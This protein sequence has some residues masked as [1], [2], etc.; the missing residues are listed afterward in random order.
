MIR[1]FKKEYESTCDYTLPDYMG[2]V[3]KVLLT[4][5]AVIPS[6]AFGSSESIDGTGIVE[7]NVIYLDSDGKM[8]A[9]CFTSDYEISFPMDFEPESFAVDTAISSYSVH[10]SAPRRFSAKATVSSELHVANAYVDAPEGSAFEDGR[11]PE[12]KRE[13]LRAESM[14]TAERA[15]R[16]YAETLAELGG[17]TA[18]DIEVISSGAVLR[19]EE[20][21]AVTDGVNVKGTLIV[22]AIVR[23]SEQAPFAIKREFPFEE[24]IRIE[25]AAPDMSAVVS[26]TVSSATCTTGEGE[27]V[28]TVV[29]NV[30][31]DFDARLIYNEDV[32]VTSDAYLSELDTEESYA[33][34]KYSALRGAVST[35]AEISL[36]NLRSE[37]GLLD[38]RELLNMDFDVRKCRLDTEDGT[39]K[40]RGELA[41]F[42]I[43]SEISEDGAA[44]YSPVRFSLPFEI[45]LGQYARLAPDSRVSYSVSPAGVEW[46]LDA[47]NVYLRASVNLSLHSRDEKSARRLVSCNAV[48]EVEYLPSPSRITVYYPEGGETLFSVAKKF[49]TTPAQ[50]SL[51]NEITDTVSTGDSSDVS[52]G[53]TKILVRKIK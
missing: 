23:T 29:A 37:S 49:H 2:D 28:A 1:K 18:D 5:A 31:A 4:K 52:V 22:T 50:L 45:D 9:A 11:A 30:I 10:P 43:S 48:G 53:G 39:A 42:G 20:A 41:F 6:G 35:D 27:G 38:A 19:I 47:E 17:L 8:T 24:T 15:E 12:L 40:I 44:S 26:S 32:T 33:D 25:G 46:S 21:V 36:R 34:M 51:D 13:T 7:Y 16:E 14:L 3:R